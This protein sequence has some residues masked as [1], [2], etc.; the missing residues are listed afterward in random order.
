ML[1]KTW[2]KIVFKK[3]CTLYIY[4]WVTLLYSRNCR[5]I[6]NQL[7]FIKTFFKN[8]YP[9][10]FSLTVTEE[11]L[12]GG[13]NGKLETTQRNFYFT[14]DQIFLVL[15]C[16][17]RPKEHSYTLTRIPNLACP[18]NTSRAPEAAALLPALTYMEHLCCQMFQILGIHREIICELWISLLQA[19][20][21]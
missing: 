1:L 18:A 4:D 2:W 13:K 5:N 9:R 16:I 8:A 21:S 17:F 10:I 19:L 15:S 14:V 11:W 3:E 12:K 6:I 20:T 7:Y